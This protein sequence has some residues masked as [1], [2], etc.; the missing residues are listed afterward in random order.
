[1]PI[2]ARRTTAPQG[3][4]PAG[5]PPILRLAQR[6]D[7]PRV[8]ALLDQRQHLLAQ[9]QQLYEAAQVLGHDENLVT[10]TA[11]VERDPQGDSKIE[12]AH[13]AVLVMERKRAALTELLRENSEQTTAMM[14]VVA[15]E[16]EAEVRLALRQ[17]LEQ[18]IS[19]LEAAIPACRAIKNLHALSTLLGKGGAGQAHLLLE[20]A[21]FVR[22][23]RSTLTHLQREQE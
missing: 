6:R 2:L 18:L 8:Q 19:T 1:M 23:A 13:D 12:Q 5:L 9:Q 7:D 10:R 14:G 16:A 21:P 20:F 15:T 22:L 3:E 4:T 11:L 17:P